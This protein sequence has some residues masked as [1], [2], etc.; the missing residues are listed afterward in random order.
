[1]IRN[2]IHFISFH[3]VVES[4]DV[5]RFGGVGKFSGQHCIHVDPTA[6]KKKDIVNM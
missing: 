6:K 4:S 5:E 2:R 1:M 3:F